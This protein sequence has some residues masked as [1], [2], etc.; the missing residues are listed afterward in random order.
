MDD[1]IMER[2]VKD[3]EEADE[4][5]DQFAGALLEILA[6]VMRWATRK[7]VMPADAAGLQVMSAIEKGMEQ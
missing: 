1:I 7:T 2:I 4:R 5:G 3:I 6:L